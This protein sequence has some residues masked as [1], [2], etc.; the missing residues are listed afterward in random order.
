M[1]KKLI[2]ALGVVGLFSSVKADPVE[3]VR[4][5]ISTARERVDKAQR[6]LARTQRL[7]EEATAKLG[8]MQRDQETFDVRAIQAFRFK[9]REKARQHTAAIGQLSQRKEELDRLQ[10]ELRATVEQ[11][12]LAQ[13]ER[14]RMHEEHLET[15]R[16]EEERKSTSRVQMQASM[17]ERAARESET[18]R[19]AQ[20]AIR[21]RREAT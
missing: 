14:V 4:Q 2:L 18:E 8:S 17:R 15:G 9:V 20:E 1:N 3:S 12:T 16:V 10:D 7:A 11:E 19:A 13:S 5:A 21:A 6:S